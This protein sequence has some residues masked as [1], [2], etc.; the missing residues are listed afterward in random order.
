[1][2]SRLAALSLSVCVATLFFVADLASKHFLFV[3]PDSPNGFSFFNGWI[4]STQFYNH[5]ITFNIPVPTFLTLLITLVALGWIVKRGM[6]GIDKA[7]GILLFVFLGI[8]TGGIL[9][10][11]FDRLR[12]DYVR[13]WILIGHL[14]ALNIA[15]CAII[16][17]AIGV[18]WRKPEDRHVT[19]K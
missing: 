1:M 17:G 10:N 4:E 18:L 2:A 11:A 7:E 5:G 3:T 6:K 15:D 13:D 14:S 12:F 9:G 19:R 8:L 16:I